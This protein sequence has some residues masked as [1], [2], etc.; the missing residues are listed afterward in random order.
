MILAIECSTPAASV[1]LGLPDGMLLE[2]RA[3]P[4]ETQ[5]AFL[6]PA[7]E[8]VLAEAGLE[9]RALGLIAAS[10]GPGAFTGVR[11]GLSVAQGL[12]FGLAVP[13]VGVSSL[14]ALALVA[15]REARP[16]PGSRLLA[17]LDARMGEVYA[18]RF[19]LE[20]DG[21]PEA[22]GE[23]L[24][25]EPA[26]AAARL[27]EAPLA[28][29]AGSGLAVAPAAWATLQAERSCR[30]LP[31]LLPTAR[32]VAELGLRAFRAGGGVPARQLEPLYLRDKVALTEAERG[33]QSSQR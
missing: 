24:L 14:A 1:A 11:F 32:A 27:G 21:W 3:A 31:E 33:A 15:A 25:A 16:P 9:R 26:A 22:E 2:R 8:A 5:S 19:R 13:A 10:R 28:L 20:G 23:P 12:A 29:I 6:L 17:L 7:I 18:G 4:G 30:L